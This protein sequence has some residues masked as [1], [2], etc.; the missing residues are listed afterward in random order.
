[1][2]NTATSRQFYVHCVKESPEEVEL[3]RKENATSPIRCD[4]VHYMW[5]ISA[6]GKRRLGEQKYFERCAH[7]VKVWETEEY[8][9]ELY[10]CQK[11]SSFVLIER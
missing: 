2:K 5:E 9:P 1:M 8:C 6:N 11:K 3:C 10:V 4:E 7:V